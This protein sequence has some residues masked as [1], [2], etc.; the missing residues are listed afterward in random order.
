VQRVRVLGGVLCLLA[1]LG[2]VVLTGE[3]LRHPHR[4]TDLAGEQ[5]GAADPR[6]E[7]T[8]EAPLP[9][10]GQRR[11]PAGDAS[12]TVEVSSRNVYDCPQNYDGHRVRYRGE[13]VGALLWRE[14]GVWVQ[15]NDDVYAGAFGPLP[16]HR[17]FRGRNSGVGVLLLPDHAAL[18]DRVGGPQ[19]HG[20][21]IEVE[22]VFNR[23]DPTGE[24]AVIRADTA[25]MVSEGGPY[26]DPPLGDRRVVAIV[27]VLLAGV[28]VAAERKVAQ[29]R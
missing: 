27:A 6:T 3:S 2:L 1:V 9:R 20:D 7:V 15:L 17:D 23:V 13:V 19:T 25:R 10:E 4:P 22:G 8:C 28:V 14:I 18:I 26:S 24:V 5:A 29:Q 16:T 21:V 12:V 11:D